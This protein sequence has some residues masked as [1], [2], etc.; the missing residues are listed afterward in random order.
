MGIAV[1][2]IEREFII[3]SINEKQLTVRIHTA[4]K[5]LRAKIVDYNERQ[6]FLQKEDDT[7]WVEF[8]KGDEISIFIDYFGHVM[9]FETTVLGIRD[10]DLEVAFPKD[11][12]KNLQ[13]KYERVSPP[14]G[15]NASFEIEGSR[16]FLNFP[17]SEAYN[18]VTPPEVDIGFD[19]TSLQELMNNLKSKLE[20]LVSTHSIKMFRDKEPETIE[21]KVIASLGRTLYIPSTRGEFPIDE[22]STECSTITKSMFSKELQKEEN[23]QE[24]HVNEEVRSLL[25]AKK[26]EGIN[27]MMYCP[28]L[29]HEYAVG[30]IYVANTGDRKKMIGVDILEFVCQFSKVLAYSL[31][32]HGY[33]KA[34]E[35]QAITY[36]ANIIDISASGLL[37]A[38]SSEELA[39]QLGLYTDF[40]LHLQ[41]GD[42]KLK[43]PARVMRR[44]RESEMMYYGVLFLE[45]EP[46]D[47]RF[48]F[49]YVYGRPFTQEDE[50]QWEGGAA[51]PEID[52]FG[53]S[54]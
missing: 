4:Q 7:H 28:I 45:M 23:V 19:D 51:P 24:K 1:G 3:K 46:E 50:E 41:I 37:F 49:D 9:T 47:F 14:S 29:Y 27:S 5:K 53:D 10:K 26:E 32:M 16:I 42:R 43:I 33:F 15:L 34:G 17:K 13:R 52:I 2:R 22:P 25:D 31:K 35:P 21:E 44:F 48:L 39:E 6:I 18:P 20:D 36:D 8:K 38:H 30:Y 40:N 12:V 11:L 54:E